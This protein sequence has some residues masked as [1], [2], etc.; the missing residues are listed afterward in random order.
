MND[1][2][3]KL[4]DELLKI[5]GV[6]EIIPPHRDDGFSSFVYKNKDF[7][8]F[9]SNNDNEIDVRLGKQIIKA[10]KVSRPTDSEVHPDRAAG[11]PWIELRYHNQK[12][13]A[14][15]VRLIKLALAEM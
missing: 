8:H 2:R 7:A 12:D 15:V 10:H 6:I 5:P 13:V 1:L 9:H 11:S 4:T 14:E 3:R